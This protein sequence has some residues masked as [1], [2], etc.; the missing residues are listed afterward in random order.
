[1]DTKNVIVI[2][3]VIK[4]R[5]KGGEKVRP[6]SVNNSHE[7][8]PDRIVLP[9]DRLSKV[10]IWICSVYVVAVLLNLAWEMGR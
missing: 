5:R 4:P 10:M 2:S 9:M 3:A 7:D 8:K 6:Q 1:M